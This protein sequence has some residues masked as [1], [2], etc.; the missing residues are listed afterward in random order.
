MSVI[1]HK[2]QRVLWVLVGYWNITFLK[3]RKKW[4]GMIICN[5]FMNCRKTGNK[6]QREEETKLFICQ[7]TN[8]HV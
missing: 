2:L 6:G 5:I 4:L 8:L 7:Y 1:G 3:T